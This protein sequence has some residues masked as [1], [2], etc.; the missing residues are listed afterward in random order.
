MLSGW[1]FISLV[2]LKRKIKS[3]KDIKEDFLNTIELSK[4]ITYDD[5]L[6]GR[7]RGWFEAILRLFAPLL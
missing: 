3:S 2:C 5:V 6:R 4:E 1:S 7:F